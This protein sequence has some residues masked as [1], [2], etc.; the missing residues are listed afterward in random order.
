MKRILLFLLLFVNLQIV[1]HNGILDCSFTSVYAQH[2]TREAGDNCYDSEIGWYHSPFSD[3]KDVDVTPSC[4]YC[5]T[6]FNTDLAR[7]E[8][9]KDCPS[10][11]KAYNCN[12]CNEGFDGFADFCNHED[13][14][15]ERFKCSRCG[16]KFT[17]QQALNSHQCGGHNNQ[18]GGGQTGK[19]SG[20][21]TSGPS[22]GGIISGSNTGVPTSG[23]NTSVKFSKEKY[24]KASK[25]VYAN[26]DNLYPK[27]TVCNLGLQEMSKKLFGKILDELKGNANT[28]YNNL[29]K[30]SKWHKIDYT[31]ANEYANKGYFVVAA[32]NSGNSSSGHVAT[33]LPGH[34]GSTWNDIFVM[35]TGYAPWT[36]PTGQS[37]NSRSEEQN[38]KNSFGSN[39]RNG[40]TGS[41][42]IYYYE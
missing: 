42:G 11:P 40:K 37:G 8:H 14:C 27:T 20:G 32:W 1:F 21:E 36:T 25:E 24:I 22:N 3:C 19:P 17:S 16:N 33:I 28:I 30:S 6:N 5:G 4:Q 31:K 38:I 13:H 9:E 15:P 29:E 41:F 7:R 34:T 35:D 23:S 18:G 26:L 12:Y 10:K 2:M 39:K